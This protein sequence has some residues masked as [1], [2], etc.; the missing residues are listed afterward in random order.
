MEKQ[1]EQLD[2]KEEIE[3]EIKVR[4]SE[5]RIRNG[6]LGLY[7]QEQQSAATSEEK[8]HLILSFLYFYGGFLV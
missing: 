8:L 2:T 1:V 7:W 4:Y 6:T 3:K 5:E